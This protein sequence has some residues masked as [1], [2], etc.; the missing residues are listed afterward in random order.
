MA[1][2]AYGTAVPALTNWQFSFS[3]FT[4]GPSTPLELKK[5]EGL[6]LPTVR[7]GDAGRPRDHG[8]FVG[9]DVMGGREITL[10]AQLHQIKGTFAEHWES[11]AKATVPGGSIETPLFVNVP[12]F[13][14]LATNV[15]VRKRAM[16]V[17]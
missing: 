14:T 13:G 17:D 4:M 1:F 7:A 6:D 12:G 2:P 11:F 15:R 3:G 9:L 16:P 10:T 8:L 5:I